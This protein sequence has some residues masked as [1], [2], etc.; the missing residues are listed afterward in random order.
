MPNPFTNHRNWW[1]CSLSE[2]VTSL[3]FTSTN[4]A[5]GQTSHHQPSHESL[6]ASPGHC[7][8][9]TSIMWGGIQRLM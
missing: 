2:F 4:D 3:F 8:K 9:G 5:L 7:P 6:N 1:S